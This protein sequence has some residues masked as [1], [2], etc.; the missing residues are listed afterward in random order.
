[1]NKGKI[2]LDKP[3]RELFK[4]HIPYL[5]SLGIEVPQSVL[6]YESIRPKNHDKTYPLNFE[7]IQKIILNFTEKR[8][9]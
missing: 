2:V 6:V 1:M 9:Q 3:P 4:E 5:Q 8:G 7:E